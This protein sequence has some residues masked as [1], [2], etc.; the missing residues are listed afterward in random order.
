VSSKSSSTAVLRVEL[1]EPLIWRRMRVTGTTN[2]R[3]PHEILQSVLGW[4][5]SHLHEFR[6]GDLMQSDTR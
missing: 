3:T 1:L 6:A 4:Q 5:N 2:F